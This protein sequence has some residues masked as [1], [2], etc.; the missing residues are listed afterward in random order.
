M[1][2]TRINRTRAGSGTSTGDL[3]NPDPRTVNR[4]TLTDTHGPPTHG[5]PHIEFKRRRSASCCQDRDQ[6]H[7]DHEGPEH[8]QHAAVLC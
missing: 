2:D 3:D 8:Q 6:D 1:H 7:R 4:K 5:E